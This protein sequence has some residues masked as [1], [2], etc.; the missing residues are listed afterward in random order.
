MELTD[1]ILTI[2]ELADR[3]KVKNSTI[4]ELTRRRVTVRCTI[5]ER[6]LAS[7]WGVNCGSTGAWFANGSRNWRKTGRPGVRTSDTARTYVL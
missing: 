7:S 5:T 3:L 6:Y 4:Y 2:Q 1:E